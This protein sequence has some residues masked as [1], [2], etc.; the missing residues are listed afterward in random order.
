MTTNLNG[1]PWQSGTIMQNSRSIAELKEY[2]SSVDDIASISEIRHPPKK[3]PVITQMA[4]MYDISEITLHRHI[5]GTS[6]RTVAEANAEKQLLTKSEEEVLVKS[7]N[8]LFSPYECTGSEQ[9]KY[10]R[11]FQKVVQ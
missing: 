4:K 8:N 3:K 11:S 6:P 7:Q 9:E 1:S 5:K 2:S 10:D